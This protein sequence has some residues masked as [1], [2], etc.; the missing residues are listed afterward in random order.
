MICQKIN[1]QY[2]K[3]NS[4]CFSLCDGRSS[5]LTFWWT[6]GIQ[7]PTKIRRFV[8]QRKIELKKVKTSLFERHEALKADRLSDFDEA[9]SQVSFVTFKARLFCL[10]FIVLDT[11]SRFVFG[12]P[13]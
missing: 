12:V 9:A 8:R 7:I 11:S 10:V 13:G 5:D 4:F 3:I 6:C 2:I 1:F